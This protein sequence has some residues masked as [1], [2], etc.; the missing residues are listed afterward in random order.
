MIFPVATTEGG[1]TF[2]FPDTCKTPSPP[3]GVITIPYPNIAQMSD[4]SG[5]S[6]VKI[7]NKEVLCKDDEIRMSSGDDAGVAGGVVSS[8]NKG[9]CKIKM[10]CSTVKAGGDEIARLTSMVGQNGSNANASAG[11]HVSPS[12]TSVRVLG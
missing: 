12:Q 9:S 1:M 3:T 7:N 10:G 6:S 8:Q 11:V 5:C 2:A 4:G